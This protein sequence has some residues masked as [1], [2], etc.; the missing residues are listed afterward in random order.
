MTAGAEKEPIDGFDIAR[1]AASLNGWGIKEPQ[2][3]GNNRWNFNRFTSEGHILILGI[4]ISERYALLNE[5][6]DGVIFSIR[7]NNI[8]GVGTSPDM[9][10]VVFKGDVFYE[11]TYAG[12]FH[13]V[14]TLN[15]LIEPIVHKS[16]DLGNPQR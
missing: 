16:Y 8:R 11:M 1:I 4:D 2:G 7:C 6:T 10:K 12:R 9:D 14:Y 5:L 13:N 3:Q 15:D